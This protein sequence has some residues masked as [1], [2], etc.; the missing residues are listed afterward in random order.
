M[1]EGECEIMEAIGGYFELELHK[2]EEYH[3]DAISLNTARNCFEYILLARNYKKVYIPY[4]TCEVMLQPL[5][6]HHISYEFYS[7]NELL[8]PIG[9][10][11]L[12]PEEA[13]LYTNYFGLK[14][15]CVEKLVTIYGTQLIMHKHFL[16]L[17]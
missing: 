13:F 10:T 16:L 4:Y 8:E 1:V 17:V 14:Q 15:S 7:I 3:K 6:K 2:G 12:L 5:E 9:I 11:K